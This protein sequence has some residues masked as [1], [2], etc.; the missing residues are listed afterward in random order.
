V[1]KVC[2]SS[3]VIVV[4]GVVSATESCTLSANAI[5]RGIESAAEKVINTLNKNI[6]SNLSF[7][8][9]L[10]LPLFFLYIILL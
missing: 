8:I 7:D 4:R 5:G 2:G 1:V 6:F 9:N 10:L 3:L